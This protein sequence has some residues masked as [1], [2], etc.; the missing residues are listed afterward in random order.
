MLLPSLSRGRA[1]G[2]PPVGQGGR[3]S[4]GQPDIMT[5]DTP[6]GLAGVEANARITG[7]MGATLFVLF[8][9]E[10]LTILLRVRGVLSAHVF[11][12]MLLVPPVLVK[13]ASTGYRIA[14]Y[15]GGDPAYVRKGPPPILLRMLGPFVIATTFLV[16]GTGIALLLAG[17]PS[18]W[19]GRA[20][21]ASFVLWFGAMAIH[22]LGHLRETPALAGADFGRRAASVPGAWSRRLLLLGVL[23][24]GVLLGA[25]SL[26]WIGP[27][28]HDLG[29][30]GERAL[31][32]RE[33]HRS[34]VGLEGHD[35][36]RR[37]RSPGRA[38]PVGRRSGP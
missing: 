27:A 33:R 13:T 34:P 15:Y 9:L 19:L 36:V 32:L 22:V 10:G 37:P 23:V 1:D 18:E 26:T 11:I 30:T 16:V 35:D 14:R 17:Q 12:G 20:H 28:W 3:V 5:A 31:A 2:Q 6:A 24:A 38:L 8:A 29:R 4:D 25:W 21:K 7:T